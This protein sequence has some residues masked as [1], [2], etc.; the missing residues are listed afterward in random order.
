[1][2]MRET[3]QGSAMNRQQQTLLELLQ[4][5]HAAPATYRQAALAWLERDIGFDGAVWGRGYRLP[6]GAIHI[7]G[8]E[9]HGRPT[10]LLSE[11]GA[12]AALDPVSR[13]FAGDPGR[14]WNVCV[15][16]DYR[17]HA[18]RPVGAYLQRYRIGQFLLCGVSCPDDASLAWL[19][20]YREDRRRPFSVREADLAGFAVPFVLLA[21]GAVP[22]P[23][24]EPAAARRP[25]LAVVPADTLSH[26][27]TEVAH[28]YAAGQSYKAIARALA[29]SPATVRSHLLSIFRKLEVHN[30]I[31]LRRRLLSE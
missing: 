7:A 1:M 12:V 21:E 26:R 19:T 27:E 13:G 22:P 8:A 15:A 4:I 28:A 5:A 10:A 3:H 17:A 30:K 29:V 24:P 23:Q 18:V 25:A 9:V 20:L 31:E 11:F 14:L 2:Q 6:D 16:R